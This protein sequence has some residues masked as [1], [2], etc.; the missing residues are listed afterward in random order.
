MEPLPVLRWVYAAGKAFHGS[1]PHESGDYSAA[2]IAVQHGDL[3]RHSYRVAGGNEVPQQCYLDSTGELADDGGV[4]VDG[5]F[6]APVRGVVLVARDPVKAYLF[7]Q[8]ILFVV[9]VVQMV[10]LLGIEIGVWEIQPARSVLGYVRIHNVAVGL[11]T[12]AALQSVA[13]AS[14]M[15]ARA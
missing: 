12:P 3:F 10:G 7:G 14:A 1:G 13:I 11:L 9:L 6:H 4:Q 8:Y 5:G 15:S 2:G